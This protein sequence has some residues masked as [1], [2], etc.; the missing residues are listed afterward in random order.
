MNLSDPLWP[1]KKNSNDTTSTNDSTYNGIPLPINPSILSTDQTRAIISAIQSSG[2]H[3]WTFR[4][5]W[6]FTIPVTVATVVIPMFIG[7]VFR[8][9]S[10]FAIYHRGHWR[11]VVIIGVVGL[12]ATLDY[13]VKTLYDFQFVLIAVIVLMGLLALTL[14]CRA[15]YRKKNRRMW[16]GFTITVAIYPPVWW[17]NDG[18]FRSYFSIFIPLTYVLLVW[19]RE[20][21]RQLFRVFTR[22]IGSCRGRHDHR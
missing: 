10:R 12:V 5:Y 8:S 4:S 9:V 2:S 19:S 11:F 17:Y 6:Y 7:A 20:E 13:L 3:L 18:Y 22:N 15:L 14:T 16:C 21:L 1:A